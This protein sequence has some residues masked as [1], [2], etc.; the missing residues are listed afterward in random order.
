MRRDYIG[1]VLVF[2]KKGPMFVSL[3]G[4]AA[5]AIVAEVGVCG[6]GVV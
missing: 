5:V 3:N 4:L 1:L 6:I 2:D